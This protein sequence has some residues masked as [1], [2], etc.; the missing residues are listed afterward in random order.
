[1]WTRVGGLPAWTSWPSAGPRHGSPGLREQ[2]GGVLG[3]L[4]RIRIL[5]DVLFF[6]NYPE[7]GVCLCV[8]AC[9]YVCVCVVWKFGYYSCRL[10][11]TLSLFGGLNLEFSTIKTSPF[12]VNPSVCEALI[13]LPCD[14]VN[15]NFKE[16]SGSLSVGR[17]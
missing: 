12:R 4:W 14:Q 15:V 17:T 8:C 10:D 2:V 16:Y 6:V 1:M 3:M 13:F 11:V 5:Q 9:I 7:S